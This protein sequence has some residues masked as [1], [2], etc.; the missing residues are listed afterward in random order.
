LNWL[1]EYLSKQGVEDAK[2]WKLLREEQLVAWVRTHAHKR[3]WKQ[4]MQDLLVLLRYHPQAF[5]RAYQK[6]RLRAQ[7]RS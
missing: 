5:V 6:L 1:E 4:A 3:E 2:I 7:L